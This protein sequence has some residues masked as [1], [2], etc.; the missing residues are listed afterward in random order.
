MIQ[1]AQT[2]YGDL[3]TVVFRK[4]LACFLCPVCDVGAERKDALHPPE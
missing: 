1:K 3:S 4:T 2:T